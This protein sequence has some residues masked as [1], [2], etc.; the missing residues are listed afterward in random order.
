VLRSENTWPASPE[1]VR[2]ARR[3]IAEVARVAGIP[4]QALDAVRLAVSEAVTNAVLH[5]YRGG[6]RGE[7]TVTVEAGDD[8]L[9]VRVRDHGCG[10]S[11]HVGGR[12]AGFGLPLIAEISD[13]LAVRPNADGNGTEVHMTFRMPADAPA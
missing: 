5:G 8:R 4:E 3:Q 12:G 2:D 9:D 10:M 1:H 13:G 6:G 11:P 7:V